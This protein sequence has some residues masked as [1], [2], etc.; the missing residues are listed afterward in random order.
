[1]AKA[2]KKNPVKD[3]NRKFKVGDLVQTKDGLFDG[4]IIGIKTYSLPSAETIKISVLSGK[5]TSKMF[6]STDLILLEGEEDI[7]KEKEVQDE[8]EKDEYGAKTDQDDAC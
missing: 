3:P 8:F 1:M 7:K 5:G 2:K 6:L 4:K